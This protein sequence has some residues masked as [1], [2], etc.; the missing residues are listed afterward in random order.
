MERHT[1]SSSGSDRPRP[2]AVPGSK[3]A[4]LTFAAVVS[5]LAWSCSDALAHAADRGHVLL[6]PTDY[7][8]WGGAMAVALSFLVL[9]IAPPV[10]LSRLAERRLHLGSL[11]TVLRPVSSLVCFLF[12]CAL[13][14]TGFLGSRDPLSNPLPLVVWTIFWV[15]FTLLQGVAGNVSWWIT[16]WYAPWRLFSRLLGKPSGYLPLPERVGYWPAV[17][18]FAGFAWFELVYPAPDDPERL[19]VA[20]L[21]YFSGNL[22]AMLVF[23]HEAWSRRGECLSV[24]L[25]MIARL[26]I[27]DAGRPAQG[28][29]SLALCLP[30]ARL[31][32]A[33]A[34]P[35]S[36]VLFLLL[37]LGSV[38][39]DGLMRTF[40]W[41]G[42]FGVNPLE[43]PG[44]TA[45]MGIGGL[46]LAATF[47]VLAAAFLAAVGAGERLAGRRRT[48]GSAGL[49][50]WSIIPI[51][52]AF[53]FSH[54]LTALVIN[55]QYALA[56]LSDPLMSGADLFG[57]AGMHV[58][59]GV[60]MGADSAWIVWNLQAAS[61]I[62]GHLLAVLVAHV[63]AWRIHGSA[64]GAVRSQLPLAA[65]MVLYTVFGL[66][67]L[68]SPTAM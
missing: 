22:V 43:F 55:G 39:F 27:V 45:V 68:S 48:G 9:A 12:L 41:L 4:C 33:P 3:R 13:L 66:W 38:S 58:R 62:A 51:S 47:L 56:A 32:T 35:L 23:G 14:A 26:G 59:A 24:F 15:G 16:P 49:L 30:G 63:I 53:H 17:L 36:G 18:Q 11:P 52:M 64:R 28:R 6:L 65:L 1:Y 19:A 40:F 46:G 37:A 20:V 25:G 50:V 8:L 10:P 42:L 31:V 34:L 2:V 67:L 61:I 29:R 57:T 44:R 54:Y 7:Y 21:V 60:L 5:A